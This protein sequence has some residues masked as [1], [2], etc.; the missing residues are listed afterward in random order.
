MAVD[1]ASTDFQAAVDRNRSFGKNRRVRSPN[2]KLK[3]SE[4]PAPKP[5]KGRG[6]KSGTTLII[7]SSED[8]RQYNP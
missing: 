7:V 2:P 3:G 5:L 6:K 1:Y 8:R 4:L